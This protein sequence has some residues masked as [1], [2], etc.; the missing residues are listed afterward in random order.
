MGTNIKVGDNVKCVNNE[1]ID[2][3]QIFK[4]INIDK[5]FYFT[6]FCEKQTENNSIVRRWFRETGIIKIS[7]SE[8]KKLFTI[9]VR[10]HKRLNLK[11]TL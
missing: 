4:V 10:K 9:S 6:Y 1:D 8:I 11:F 7:K 2:F 3:K 5:K